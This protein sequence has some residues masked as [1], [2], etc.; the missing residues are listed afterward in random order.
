LRQVHPR[1]PRTMRGVFRDRRIDLSSGEVPVIAVEAGSGAKSA[2]VSTGAQGDADRHLRRRL[3]RLRQLRR[4]LSEDGG[5]HIEKRGS[6]A[7]SRHGAAPRLSQAVVL[8]KEHDAIL[9]RGRMTEG[10][11]SLSKVHGA[12]TPIRG[13]R[14][15]FVTVG[16]MNHEVRG[17]RLRE[18]ESRPRRR[19]GRPWACRRAESRVPNP[20]CRL[21][22]PGPQP[23]RC[24]CRPL[25]LHDPPAPP[26]ALLEGPRVNFA[27]PLPGVTP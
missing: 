7:A 17:V 23:G 9:L 13:A 8:A 6:S 20:G 12:V 11:F 21:A 14:R 26:G 19:S 18:S 24:P 3:Q 10:D 27:T 5:P 15:R 22:S 4:V 25:P 2:G 16:W 1:M